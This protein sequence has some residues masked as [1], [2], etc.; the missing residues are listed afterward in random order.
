MYCSGKLNLKKW[1][2]DFAFDRFYKVN[3]CDG[4]GKTN[5]VQVGPSSGHDDWNK[6]TTIENVIQE[7]EDKE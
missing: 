3:D 6:L 1:K 2:Q 5:R 7:S 4:C